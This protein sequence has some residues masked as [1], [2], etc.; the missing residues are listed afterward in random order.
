[1]KTIA[2]IKVWA[3]RQAPI[4][5]QKLSTNG[6]DEDWIAFIPA[7]IGLENPPLWMGEGTPFGYCNVDQYT[8]D[9]GTI[10]IGS[11]A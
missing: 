5:Y 1:M 2:A 11:H 4:A 8:V 3:F 9:G 10:Y 6:G 7:N